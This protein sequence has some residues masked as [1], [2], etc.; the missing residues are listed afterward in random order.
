MA[1]GDEVGGGEEGGGEAGEEEERQLLKEAIT[2]LCS[3]H[4]LIESKISFFHI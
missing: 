3:V 1:A 4:L 2:A